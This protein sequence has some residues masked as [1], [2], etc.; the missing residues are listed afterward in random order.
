M[1]AD[2]LS[3]LFSQTPIETASLFF[4]EISNWFSSSPS[5]T[6]PNK[7]FLPGFCGGLAE[8]LPEFRST[9][10]VSKTLDAEDSES[11][12][13]SDIATGNGLTIGGCSSK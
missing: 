4:L 11:V 6:L 7:K 12:L 10:A 9:M 13:E 8:I 2:A 1:A 5:E 3:L